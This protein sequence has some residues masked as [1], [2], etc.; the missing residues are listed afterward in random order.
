MDISSAQS[1]VGAAAASAANNK[2]AEL[3]S[4]EFLE[5]MFTELQNQDPLEPQ[6]SG[7][8][9]EQLSSIRN[10][11]SQLSLQQ[12]METIVSQNQLSSASSFIGQEITGLDLE[13][14]NVTGLVASVRVSGKDVLLELD[15]GETVNMNQVTRIVQGEMGNGA[16]DANFEA[17]PGD[18]NG[19]GRVDELDVNNVMKNFGRSAPLNQDGTRGQLDGDTNGNGVVDLEDLAAVT[20][21][22][23]SVAK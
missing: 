6:D 8:L 7:A 14:N 4:S 12:T 10:I 18:T 17:I 9:L 16:V 19:D 1:G 3:S 15:S 5:V 13:N 11:E 23:G 21:Y 22:Y 2:F 20:Q